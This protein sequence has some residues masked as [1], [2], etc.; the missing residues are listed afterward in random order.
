M[1]FVT[2][3]FTGLELVFDS[4]TLINPLEFLVIDQVIHAFDKELAVTQIWVK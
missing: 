3:R 1:K 4:I 2:T